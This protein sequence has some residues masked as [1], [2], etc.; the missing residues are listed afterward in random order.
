[1]HVVYGIVGLKT[2]CKLS[3][4]VRQEPDGLRRYCHIG[5]GNYNPKTARLYTDHG[6]LT[7][8][9]EVGQDLTRLFNQLSGYAP[10]SRFHRLLVAPRSLRAGLDRAHRP[11]GGR[12]A[13]G[14][15]G[16]DQ[17]Q[18]QLD[19]RRGHDRRAVPGVAGGRPDRHGGPWHLRPASRGPGP[20]RDHPGAL[21]PRPVP[22][23]L[24]HLRV[25]QRDLLERRRLRGPGG[26]HR[27]RGPDAPQPRPARRGAGP[28]RR[29]RPGRRAHRAH[30]RV[31]RRRHVLVAPRA[32]R[33]V[34]AAP[35]AARTARSWTCR[36]RSSTGSGAGRARD[37]DRNARTGRRRGGRGPGVAR[38]AGHAAGRPGAPAALRRLVVAEGQGRPRRDDPRGGDARGRRGDRSRRRPRDPAAR[39]RVPAVRRPPQARALLGRPGGRP[40]RRRR[41]ARPPAG[42]AGVAEGDRP[43]AVVR[44]GRRRPSG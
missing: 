20:V 30:G 23:A 14:P 44:R 11:G 39:A 43:A 24:A 38:P 3:L 33:D 29:P 25:R 18:G 36:P 40:P 42:A 19:G 22:G 35:P 8:D 1:M 31:D 6:L 5:T 17:D 15:A 16:V 21:D 37:G 4:V 28:H 12:R 26:L 7:S 41:A 13:D 10:K 2:H 9:P 27:L 32:G 34:A